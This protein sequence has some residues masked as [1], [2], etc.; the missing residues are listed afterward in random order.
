[1]T[2]EDKR[3]LLIVRQSQVQRAIEYF[4]LLD[5]KPDAKTLLTTADL[6][7]EYV[8]DG[9]TDSV[10]NRCTR[11]DEALKKSLDR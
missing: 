1:M 10:K 7:R 8:Y 9:L 6:F 4:T 3:Q 2:Q 5:I 11:M